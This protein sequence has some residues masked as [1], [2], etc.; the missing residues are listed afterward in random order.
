[1]KQ[2]NNFNNQS[3]NNNYNNHSNHG[4]H[5][6][7]QNNYKNKYHNYQ[8]N[9]NSSNNN[10]QK[11][12]IPTSR[13]FSPSF[14]LLNSNNSLLRITSYN[15]LCDSLLPVSLGISD[16]D[17]SKYKFTE[18]SYRKNIIINELKHY[19]SDIIGIQEFEKDEDFIERLKQIG[20]DILFIPRPGDHSE[21]CAVLFKNNK[22]HLEN[23]YS[24]SFNMNKSTSNT[25]NTNNTNSS[26]FKTNLVSNTT[27]NSKDEDILNKLQEFANIPTDNTNNN[28]PNTKTSINNSTEVSIYDRDNCAC[29]AVFTYTY[30]DSNNNKKEKTIIVATSHLLFNIKRGDIKISQAYQLNIAIDKLKEQ[31]SKIK[32]IKK[33]S[34]CSFICTDMNSLPCSGIYKFMR[35]GEFDVSSALIEQLSGQHIRVD[36]KNENKA[37]FVKKPLIYKT[38]TKYEFNNLISKPGCDNYNDKVTY[39]TNKDIKKMN[40]DIIRNNNNTNNTVISESKIDDKETTI[41]NNPETTETSIPST[42]KKN[43]N[44]TNPTVS[45][46]D[47]KIPE[48]VLNRN[49]G[50]FTE[51]ISVEVALNN[52]LQTLNLEQKHKNLNITNSTQLVLKSPIKFNS[53]YSTILTQ[54]VKAFT[55]KNLNFHP[56]NKYKI[57]S[58]LNIDTL[59]CFNYLAGK[60]SES[61]RNF[62]SN[63]ACEPFLTT[64]TEKGYNTV[65]YIFYEGEGVDVLRVLDFPDF[66]RVF[67]EICLMPNDYFPSDHFSLT[68]DFIFE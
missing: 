26:L 59:S 14:P 52:A 4:N 53:A 29:I 12:L 45:A 11:P 46:I 50:W 62:F 55:E 41:S 61:T 66:E 21:G 40:D 68:A 30:Q 63:L 20:Y 42:T 32:K 27:N 18:W 34:I 44:T 8:I 33:E 38:T 37:H 19:D 28:K 9:P 17:I 22:L 60:D 47:T 64:C 65:D 57:P 2:N 6:N 56:F 36:F 3:N 49:I 23:I 39:Y 1:M 5:N 58:D 51:A 13:T 24:L 35:E 54:Y 31:F 15:I 67:N 25:S 7:Y 43:I 48:L 10:N 16:E